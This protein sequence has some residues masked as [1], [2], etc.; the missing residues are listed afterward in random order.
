MA[1]LVALK[2]E[3]SLK[4]GDSDFHDH[5]VSERPIQDL[6]EGVRPY[7]IL[8]TQLH[9]RETFAQFLTLVTISDLS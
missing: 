8:N 9:I 1:F 3:V 2:E 6:R 7:G 4:R 5:I